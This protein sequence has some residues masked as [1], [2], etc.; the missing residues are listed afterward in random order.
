MGATTFWRLALISFS[1]FLSS[2]SSVA[3]KPPSEAIQQNKLQ[4]NKENR[5]LFPSSVSITQLD[6]V[7]IVNPTTPGTTPTPIVIPTSPPAPITDPTTTPTAPTTT[8]PTAPTTTTPTTP[9]TTTPT[10][11]TT[12]TPASSGG[13]WC[14]ASQA[15]SETAL[16]VAIDYACGYGGADCSAIQPGSSCYNPNTLRD[17]ASY[18]FN[19]YYHK[20]PAPTSC[21]FGGTAQL[22]YTD[23]SSGNCHYASSTTTP[24]MS[25]PAIPTPTTPTTIPMTPPTPTMSIPGGSTIYGSEPTGSPN[26]ASSVSY[27]SLMLFTI[28]ALVGARAAYYL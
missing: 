4:H 14:I 18:A 21:V 20:N 5:M 17:H 9:T 13:S 25:S 24:S 6:T 27:C 10:T 3:E 7:P 2:G 23:P 19:D 16:Q 15:A 11:P 12:T 28:T 22:T 26:S 1:L 8:T